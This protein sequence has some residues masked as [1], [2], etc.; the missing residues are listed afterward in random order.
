VPVDPFERD[1]NY[2]MATVGWIDFRCKRALIQLERSLLHNHNFLRVAIL[3]AFVFN[4]PMR[5]TLSRC[6]TLIS[7]DAVPKK[8]L[9][10]V[11]IRPSLLTARA[12]QRAPTLIDHLNAR[13][14]QRDVE[15]AEAANREGDAPT[16][17]L[18]WPSNLRIEPVISRSTFSQVA[19]EHRTSL[20][21]SLKER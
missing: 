2:R 12:Q 19:R 7:R 20:K 16:N 14:A 18:R 10:T 11:G 21:Q 13:K 6:W 1:G 3:F 15:L 17:T 9:E 8:H 4:I 5:P